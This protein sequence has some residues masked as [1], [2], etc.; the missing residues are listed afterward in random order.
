MAAPTQEANPALLW[1]IVGVCILTITAIV[2]PIIAGWFKLR[3][4]QALLNSKMDT[5]G[6]SIAGIESDIK[7]IKNNAQRDREIMIANFASINAKMG[8]QVKI[9]G[10]RDA[11][12]S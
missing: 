9:D 3:T 6:S 7:E 1:Q 5:Q 8:I 10:N 11:G 12:A 4:D 2:A